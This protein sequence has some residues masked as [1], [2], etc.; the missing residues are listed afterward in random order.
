MMEFLNRAL[1]SPVKSTL[2]R[3]VKNGNF[4]TWPSLTE[5]KITTYL[6]KSEAAALGHIDQACKNTQSTRITSH[7]DT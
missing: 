1:F 6:A 2:L 3:E 7:T 4:A 5:K